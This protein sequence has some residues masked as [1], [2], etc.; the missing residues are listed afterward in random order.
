MLPG[1]YD[2][3]ISLENKI[4]LVSPSR[5]IQDKT[6]LRSVIFHHVPIPLTGLDLAPSRSYAAFVPA[7]G[8]ESTRLPGPV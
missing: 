6:P 7:T 2:L 4:K 3:L 5:N 1:A 8:H